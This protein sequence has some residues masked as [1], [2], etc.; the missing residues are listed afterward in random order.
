MVHSIVLLNDGTS[1]VLLNDGTSLVLLNEAG[2]P[3]GGAG[4]DDS[5]AGMFAGSGSKYPQVL[6]PPRKR[7]TIK[8]FAMSSIVSMQLSNAKSK[9]R[10]L[11]ESLSISP[12]LAQNTVGK[13]KVT[14]TKH[15]KAAGKI[16]TRSLSNVHSIISQK[17]TL[18]ASSQVKTV[19]KNM[20]KG[21]VDNEFKRLKK[22][23]NLE[24]LKE[25]LDSSD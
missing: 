12:M 18:S 17:E 13:S 15:G 19:S 16:R 14:N 1:G 6:A 20:A 7:V 22:L 11:S 3:H 10:T 24:K 25:L 23:Y 9:L 4:I 8:N 2:P 21:K 5:T